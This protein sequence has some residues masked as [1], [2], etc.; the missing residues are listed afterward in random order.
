MESSDLLRLKSGAGG[1]TRPYKAIQPTHFRD[2]SFLTEAAS[3][4]LAEWT[5]DEGR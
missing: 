1:E 4:T 2:V 3:V 5:T